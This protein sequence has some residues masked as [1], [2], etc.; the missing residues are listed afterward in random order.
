MTPKKKTKTSNEEKEKAITFAW[1]DDEP[2]LLL[3]AILHFKWDKAGQ[4]Y[5]WESVKTKDRDIRDIFI[6]RYPKDDD[7]EQFSHKDLSKSFTKERLIANVKALRT[8][9]N[10]ALDSG[11]KS[12]GSHVVV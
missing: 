12:G 6:E 10:V 4:G 1:R 7:S 11:R 9:F 2:Q 3:E 5:D 8:K